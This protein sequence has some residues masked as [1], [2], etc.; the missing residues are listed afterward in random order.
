MAQQTRSEL[1]HGDVE[2][3]LDAVLPLVGTYDMLERD[4][5][6]VAEG[7]TD[8]GWIE[9][10]AEASLDLA[11]EFAAAMREEL[12]GDAYLEVGGMG[13]FTVVNY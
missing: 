5:A 11:Q 9:V 6:T 10:R 13:T 8:Q 7:R 4:L 12:P 3:A 2:Q 1:T